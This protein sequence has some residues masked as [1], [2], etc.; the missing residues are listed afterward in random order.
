[1]ENNII[2][3][4]QKGDFSSANSELNT[5]MLI[6]ISDVFDDRKKDIAHG[7]FKEKEWNI[8]LTF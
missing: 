5:Q 2:D 4:I 7:M 6:K 1:M 3:L 8:F